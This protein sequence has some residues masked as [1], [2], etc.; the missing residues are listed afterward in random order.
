V[1]TTSGQADGS[2]IRQSRRLLSGPKRDGFGGSRL[3]F[4]NGVN[5]GFGFRLFD[6]SVEPLWRIRK[7]DAMGFAKPANRDFLT[8]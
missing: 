3:D 2:P 7:R 5:L 4:D 1:R 6:E 8:Q